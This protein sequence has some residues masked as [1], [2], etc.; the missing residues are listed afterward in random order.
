MPPHP[1]LVNEPNPNEINE[2]LKK[3]SG[4]E[5]CVGSCKPK[6]CRTMNL[7]PQTSDN[8]KVI[9]AIQEAYVAANPNMKQDDFIVEINEV[10][11]LQDQS[12]F[13]LYHQ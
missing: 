3:R 5:L 13:V 11:N 6:I 2:E 12:G 1:L 8:D 7:K 4:I 9:A 10:Q